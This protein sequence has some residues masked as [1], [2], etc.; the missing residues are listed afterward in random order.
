MP[1]LKTHKSAS[2]RLKLTGAGKVVARHANTAHRARFKSK[3][4]KQKSNQKQVLTHL[5]ATKLGVII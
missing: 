2:K 5:G 4:S 1:K 3:R